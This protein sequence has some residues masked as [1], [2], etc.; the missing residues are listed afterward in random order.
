M[1]RT[2]LLFFFSLAG[3][4]FVTFCHFI[5]H[6]FEAFLYILTVNF[7][8]KLFFII[9]VCIALAFAKRDFDIQKK[10]GITPKANMF[11]AFAALMCSV[12]TCTARCVLLTKLTQ[13][14]DD[15]MI[16][17]FYFFVTTAIFNT[18]EMDLK[19]LPQE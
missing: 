2:K 17:V 9:I 3:L 1:Y 7:F 6:N 14:T 11:I 18:V 8:V 5:L 4:F 19:E 16:A 10:T 15:I 12:C 13:N